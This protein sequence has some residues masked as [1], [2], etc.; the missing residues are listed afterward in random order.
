MRAR[1]TCFQALSLSL[2]VVFG[3]GGVHA[4]TTQGLI[5][6]RVIN[7][8]TGRPVPEA[9][10][11]YASTTLAAGGALKS[12]SSG[13]YFLPLLSAGTYTIRATAD[14]YQ[15]QELQQLE[16]AVAGRVQLDFRLRPLNDVWE[17]GQYRS[18][19]LPGT[20]TIVTFY[21]PD[22][23]TSRSGSFEAQKGQRGT[24]DTSASYVI[25]PAQIGSLPLLGRDVYTMLVSLP[26]VAADSGTGRGL[27]ISVAGQRPS[28]SNYLLDGVEN[29]NYLVTGPLN[30]VAPEAVQEYRISTNNYSA[31][32]GRT[33]GFVANAVTRAGSSDYHGIGY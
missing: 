25:D 13:Y 7:S 5:S 6:G 24:L 28:A 1:I 12:D 21:G 23:D 20:K 15:A 16:L 29:D 4:Q 2:A 14:D 22:V 18:V 3:C 9:T 32:Y 26:G 31:E 10:V 30:P 8:V 27:G 19:F 17:S 33:A 11:S